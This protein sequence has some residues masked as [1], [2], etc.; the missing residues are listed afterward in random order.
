MKDFTQTRLICPLVAD[1]VPAMR[2]DLLAAVKAGADA[3]ELRLDCLKSAPGEADLR[4][5]LEN[6]G[7]ETIATIR[8]VRQGGYY[9]GD[10][11]LRLRTLQLAERL[12]ATF[13]DVEDDVPL[14]YWPR[15]QVIVS[16]H[17]FSGVPKNLSRIVRRLENTPAAV[18]KVAFAAGGPEHALR[19]LD[20]VRACRKPAMALAMGEPGVM[21]RILAKKFGAFGTFASL[22]RGA[23]SAPGQPTLAEMQDL[24]RWDD[25]TPKTLVYG[26]VGC[27]VGHSM[28]PAIHN[29]SLK[30]A[31]LDAVYV[32]LLVESGKKP[33]DR[34]L[35]A[36]LACRWA[37]VR[38]LSVTIPHKENALAYVGAE[39]CD[40][41]CRTI[42]AIN[43]IDIGPRGSLRG[44]NTDYAAAI[45]AVCDAMG[46]RR[47]KLSGKGV[48]VLGAG[49][50]ARSLTAALRHYGA[51]VTIYNRT[52]QRGRRLAREFACRAESL[53]AAP[54][55]TAEIL[56]NCTS[57]GM[58]PNVDD[59]PVAKIPPS[60]KVVFDTI[61]NPVRT[62]L[63]QRADAAGRLCV[64][65]VEMFVNQAVAQFEAWTHKKA[66]RDVMRRV[67]LKRL[68]K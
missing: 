28:S 4:G 25:I 37:A 42:G 65:G 6:A 59:C 39:R 43:T 53:A 55:M 1:N 68:G 22:S 36:V 67:F 10:E 24:Y 40:E 35:D 44:F 26:V 50:A 48:A 21:S 56:I 57:I 66:P 45:D 52:L 61:Y 63:L 15:A 18:V 13:V 2:R 47:E 23:E 14:K 51:D 54:A 38:G 46:I 17:D 16:H 33:F 7:A 5:L 58:H 34:F 32:P 20:V 19:A 11:S 27:P 9:E 62:K 12:G 3:V 29:A 64:T 30:A 8:P 31:K 41:L 49:G 60:V